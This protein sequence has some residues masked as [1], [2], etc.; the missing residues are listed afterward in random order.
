MERRRGN[1]RKH[2]GTYAD[3]MVKT[4]LLTR[5]ICNDTIKDNQYFTN[6]I[7]KEMEASGMIV[8]THAA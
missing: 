1:R 8:G 7:M 5:I 6:I 2:S 4:G 3:L